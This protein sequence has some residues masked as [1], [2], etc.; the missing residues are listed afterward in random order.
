MRIFNVRINLD[1]LSA[2]NDTLANDTERGEWLRGFLGAARGGA[3]RFAAGTPGALGHQFGADVLGSVQELQ[4][5]QSE[6]GAMS[7]ESRRAKLGTAQPK[8]PSKHL[9]STLEGTSTNPRSTLEPSPNQ[10]NN[11]IIEESNNPIIEESNNP[12]IDE[13]T[14]TTHA[15]AH[16]RTGTTQTPQHAESQDIFSESKEEKPINPEQALAPWVRTRTQD[17]D[18]T[19]DNY[20]EI[21]A[22]VGIHGMLEVQKKAEKLAY[23]NGGKIW[24]SMLSE[25]FL[26]SDVNHGKAPIINVKPYKA[27]K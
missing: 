3:C 13:S 6:Y 4:R 21:R 15:H 19:A 9:R 11:P 17:S 2:C 16:A 1:E 27:I 23:S 5:K 20:G 10:S 12:I 14:T 25:A 22:L 8:L 18:T 7:A 24:P 26:R